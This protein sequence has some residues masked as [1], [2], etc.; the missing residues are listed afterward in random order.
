ML[1]V[2]ACAAAAGCAARPH[3]V[4]VRQEAGRRLITCLRLAE[5]PYRGEAARRACLDEAA[6][7][8]A[9]HGLERT[10]ALGDAWTARRF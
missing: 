2:L 8:C 10:C 6:A 5:R 7:Y 1:A 3:R 4:A 9:E